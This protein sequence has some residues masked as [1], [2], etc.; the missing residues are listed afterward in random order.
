MD[1][2]VA[3]TTC[4]RGLRLPPPAPGVV[5]AGALCGSRL[6]AYPVNGV[7]RTMAFSLAALMFYVPANVQDQDRKTVRA[8]SS[9]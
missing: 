5:A 7:S 8:T 1:P 4:G 9:A 6:H 2:V 3:C